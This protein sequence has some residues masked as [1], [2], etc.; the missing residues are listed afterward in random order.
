MADRSYG[1]AVD[2]IG[3]VPVLTV[4]FHPMHIFTN[5]VGLEDYER[6]KPSYHDVSALLAALIYSKGFHTREQQLITE[7]Y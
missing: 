2:W 1:T 3:K 7:I 6:I 4:Y 5:T